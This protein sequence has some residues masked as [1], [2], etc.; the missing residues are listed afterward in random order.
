MDTQKDMALQTD[1]DRNIVYSGFKLLKNGMLPVGK[2]TFEEWM[3]CGG[4]IRKATGAVH[5][6]LGDW[7]NYGE[8]NYGEMYA[9]AIEETG[10]DYGT[11]ANDKYVSSK[12]E[13]S[14]RR[15]NLSFDHHAEVAN[16]DPQSQEELLDKAE[17]ENIKR[18]DFRK[19][20]KDHKKKKEALA[21]G[22]V[23]LPAE[24]KIFNDDFRKVQI[25]ENSID[26]IITDP[27]YPGEFLPLWKDLGVFASKVLKP[28]GFLIA[29]SGEIHLPEILNLLLESGLKYYW[30]FALIHEGNTQLILPRNVMCGWKPVVIFQK[31][32]NNKIDHS[33]SDVVVSEE[34]Q[35]DMHEW[36]QSETGVK[37]L[38]ERF[39][40][41]GDVVL[42]P[43]SGSGT[44]PKVAY[45]LGR[46]A[47][48]IEINEI[49]YKLSLKR[50]HDA[51]RKD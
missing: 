41:I 17:K 4:F 21:S 30:T 19:L 13:I 49:D 12:V 40:S 23:E 11:L 36:Q 10:Y 37:S 29:Y 25:A 38:V 8:Q 46:N 50:I 28:N 33:I 2:P 26:T 35:K 5:L 31:A 20:V 32:P 45:E 9:Q 51:T 15:E 48:G 3:E 22:K 7:L 24:V 44:F 1:K 39:T 27:P 18:R 6:W 43:F 34:E 42:D 14:R 47:I 16:L